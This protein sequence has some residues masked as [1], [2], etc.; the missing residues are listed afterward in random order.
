[1]SDLI[2]GIFFLGIAGL[3]AWFFYSVY[4]NARSRIGFIDSDRMSYI[5]GSGTVVEKQITGGGRELKFTYPDDGNSFQG[6][7]SVSQAEFESAKIGD[8][9][10]IFYGIH[11]PHLWMPIKSGKIYYLSMVVIAV[12]VGLFLIGAFFIYRTLI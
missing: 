1:M 11:A 9:I 7:L 8:K 4:V 6:V 3:L 10:P 2:K 12:G 5:K